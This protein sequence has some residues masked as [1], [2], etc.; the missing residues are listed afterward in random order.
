MNGAGAPGSPSRK[1]IPVSE[2]EME[3]S[4]LRAENARLKMET[5]K[6]VRTFVSRAG[7]AAAVRTRS[8]DGVDEFGKVA[9]VDLA[10]RPTALPSTGVTQ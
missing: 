2:L 7:R 5:V 4:K 8:D 3:L 6:L 10:C 9:D 1:V